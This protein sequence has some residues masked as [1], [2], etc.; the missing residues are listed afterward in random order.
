MIQLNGIMPP[1]TTPFDAEGHL[2]L[3]G[4]AENV[5]RYNETGLIGYVA[6]GSNGEAVHLSTNE[7]AQVLETIKRAATPA[8]K[9]VAGVNEFSTRAA[10]EATRAA[11]QSGADGA[12][13]ITPYFYK[14]SMTSEVLKRFFNEVADASPIPIFIY[15]VPQNTGVV[16]DSATIASLASHGNI[17]G[18]KDS[19]GNIGTLSDTLRL[20]PADFNV[21]V[22]NGGIV[23][24]ALSMGATGAILA[25]ACVVPRACVDLFEA[26]KAGNHAKALELQNRL[27]P[28]SHMVTAG[29]GVAGLKAAMK[30]AGFSGGEPRAPLTAAN[31]ANLEKVKSVLRESGLVLNHH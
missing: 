5:A 1:L 23:Y 14:S 17:A 8:H 11:S 27:A 4:L 2:D 26:V 15:N 24:P 13:I 29:L 19:A 31:E 28:V 22:G 18:L 9:I 6:L 10:I 30:G 16:I 20:V 21:L 7:R 25:V 3:T 12:L